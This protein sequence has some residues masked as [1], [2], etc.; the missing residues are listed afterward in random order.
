MIFHAHEYHSYCSTTQNRS[1]SRHSL[2]FYGRL[3]ILNDRPLPRSWTPRNKAAELCNMGPQL[4]PRTRDSRRNET[5]VVTQSAGGPSLPRVELVFARGMP[6]STTCPKVPRGREKWRLNS[7]LSVA[8]GR[9]I[10]EYHI[11]NN[12]AAVGLKTTKSNDRR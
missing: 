3:T 8:V 4:C 9:G 6:S 5:Y 11:L 10:I 1:C 7:S 2:P 12:L